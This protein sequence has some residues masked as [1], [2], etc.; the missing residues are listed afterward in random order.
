[1]GVSLEILPGPKAM[2]LTR[3]PTAKL[4]FGAAEEAG[5]ERYRN[6]YKLFIDKGRSHYGLFTLEAGETPLEGYNLLDFVCKREDGSFT[7]PDLVEK[8]C[9][10]LSREIPELRRFHFHMLRHTYTSNLLSSG[11]SPKDVQEL[12]GHSDVSTTMNVYA[13]SSE[14]AKLSSAR[15]LDELDKEDGPES[16]KGEPE[17]KEEG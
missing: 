7:A 3:S 5:G 1:M 4:G 16:P 10:K 11:A 6:Y 12:L 8:T 14:E 2:C 9:R 15:L 17:K 13:H